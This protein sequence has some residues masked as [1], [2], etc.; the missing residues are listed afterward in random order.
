LDGGTK[1]D[2]FGEGYRQISLIL[3]CGSFCYAPYLATMRNVAGFP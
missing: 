3:G 1:R 2:T